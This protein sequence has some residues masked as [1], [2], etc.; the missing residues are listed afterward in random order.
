[1]LARTEHDRLESRRGAAGRDRLAEIPRRRTAHG[2]QSVR[3]GRGDCLWR[4]SIA[5]K[6]VASEQYSVY[7]LCFSCFNYEL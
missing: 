3:R 1:L 6:Q 2:L 5:V 4:H 7:V